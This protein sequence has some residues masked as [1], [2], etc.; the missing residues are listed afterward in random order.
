MEIKSK[1]GQFYT[2]TL[3]IIKKVQKKGR[4]RKK[5]GPEAIP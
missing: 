5:T 1:R 3:R 4:K 2:H